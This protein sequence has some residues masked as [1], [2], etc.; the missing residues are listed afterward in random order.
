MLNRRQLLLST[1]AAASLGMFGC[2]TRN[3]EEAVVAILRKRLGYLKLDEAG[4]WEFA[5]ELVARSRFN[6]AKLDLLGA[7]RPL[8]TRLSLSGDGRL[9]L[10]IRHGEERV[11]SL[12]LLSSDFFVC[13]ANQR[14]TVGYVRYYDPLHDIRA[15]A[16]P[17]ARL[18]A[19]GSDAQGGA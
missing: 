4:V 14:R 8:Y 5:R 7:L 10:D 6:P 13:G 16:N 12:F 3:E 15:C 11:L 17:F 19:K 18:A 2:R 9:D 1:L